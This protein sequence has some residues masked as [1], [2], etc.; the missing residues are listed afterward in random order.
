MVLNK[1]PNEELSLDWSCF[2]GEYFGK[3]NEITLLAIDW[4]LIIFKN[5]SLSL[6][7]H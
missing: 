7:F 6:I 5:I 3:L 4:R 2:E 1:S